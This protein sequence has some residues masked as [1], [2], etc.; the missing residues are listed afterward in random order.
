MSIGIQMP[1]WIVGIEPADWE[2]IHR[3]YEEMRDVCEANGLEAHHYDL[4]H[5]AP[6]DPGEASPSAPEA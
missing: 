2:P 6:I 4:I 5:R 1:L 3:K